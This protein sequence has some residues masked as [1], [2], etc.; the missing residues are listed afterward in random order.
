MGL[1]NA[2]HPRDRLEAAALDMARQIAANSRRA[3]IATKQ[4]V[5]R[6]VEAD[7]A[8]RLEAEWNVRLRAS[9]EHHE[10]FKAAAER[11]ASRPSA[12]E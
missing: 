5:D 1:V 12:E 2:V 7:E 8:V 9:S 3:V 11:V 4:V 10:R 6:A